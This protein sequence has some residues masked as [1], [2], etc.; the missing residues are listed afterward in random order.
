M[1]IRILLTALCVVTVSACASNSK[2]SKSKKTDTVKQQD[3][4]APR[5]LDQGDCG[6]FVWTA[7]SARRFVLFSQSKLDTAS[8]WDDSSEVDI[9]RTGFEGYAVHD[10]PPTQSFALADGGTLKLSLKD[11][12]DVDNGTR[13]KAG[14]ITQIGSDGWEKVIPVFGL[15]ACNLTPVTADYSVRTIR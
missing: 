2:S 5:N 11:P 8:W 12:E 3:R 9:V 15:A 6:L 4:L 13:Y 10:Q 14:A 7:E 1:A